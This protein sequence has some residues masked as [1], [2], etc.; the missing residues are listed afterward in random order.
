MSLELIYTSAPKGLKPGSRGFCTVA[1][2]QGMPPQLVD[3]L[4]AISGYRQIFAPQDPQA[5]LNPVACSHLKISVSGRNFHVLSRVSAAG[6]DYSQRTNKIA[7]HV[8]LDAN[9][10]PPAGP[11]WLLSS[12]GFMTTAW[13][14]PARLLP[15][16]ARPPAGNSAPAVC[17]RWQQTT[18]DAG[19][20]GVPIDAAIK[21]PKGLVTLIFK[22]GQDPL[23]LLAESLALLPAE[24]RWQA[25][26]CTYFTKLPPGVECRWRCVVE[27]SPEAKAAAG[28]VIDLCRPLG[29]PPAGEYVTAARTGRVPI[30]AKPTRRPQAESPDDSELARLLGDPTAPKRAAPAPSRSS[31]ESSAWPGSLQPLPPLLPAD[32]TADPHSKL[33][34]GG[35][36]KKE[37]AKWPYIVGLVAVALIMVAG[38]V[39]IWTASTGGPSHDSKSNVATAEQHDTPGSS[40]IGAAKKKT[41]GDATKGK[42]DEDAK[43]TAAA[44]AAKTAA[45]DAAKKDDAA[46]KRADEEAAKTAQ[47]NAKKIAEQERL[48]READ[49]TAEREAKEK[50]EAAAN[51]AINGLPDYFLLPEV[52]STDPLVVAKFKIPNGMHC[53]IEFFASDTLPPGASFSTGPVGERSPDGEMV[54]LVLPNAPRGIPMASFRATNDGLQFQ[55]ESDAKKSP[56]NAGQIRNSALRIS[57]DGHGTT[58]PRLFSLRAP[59]GPT[60]LELQKVISNDSVSLKCA[61]ADPPENGAVLGVDFVGG[62]KDLTP[63][64]S[65]TNPILFEIDGRLQLEARPKTIGLESVGAGATAP[66]GMVTVEVRYVGVFVPWKLALGDKLQAQLQPPDKRTKIHAETVAKFIDDFNARQESLGRRIKA[67]QGEEND[68]AKDK[69]KDKQQQFSGERKALEKEKAACEDDLKDAKSLQALLAAVAKE[70]CDYRVYTVVK[71]GKE[72]HKVY[73]VAPKKASETATA[74]Q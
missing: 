42:A 52:S 35:F 7:H 13:D 17:H 11:A 24:L 53:K 69:E 9:E 61:I 6:L 18:G 58:P 3:R 39:A 29:Q 32:M 63:I 56:E 28:V 37:A 21:N 30:V 65:E 59:I 25:T 43:A 72:E 14:Q 40:A 51:D 57:L 22:P 15:P 44:D 33:R 27:G 16:R 73:L 66:G 48:K 12:P 23:P 54:S 70:S 26:F 5:A 62:R 36:R 64:V 49:A 74:R 60:P 4:E 47:E 38:G 55:W 8:A 34:P 50:L 45:A 46:K 10:A 68:A 1:M 67:K 19:W 31:A 2:T 41:D 20:G 71:C